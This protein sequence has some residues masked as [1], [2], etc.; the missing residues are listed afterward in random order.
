MEDNNITIGS[1]PEFVIM[2]GDSVANALE[3]FS[4][5]FIEDLSC[6]E[7]EEP[8]EEDYKNFY[9]GNPAHHLN[10]VLNDISIKVLTESYKKIAAQQFIDLFDYYGY[11]IKDIF[12]PDEI[13]EKSLKEA[14]KLI[15]KDI[16]KQYHKDIMEDKKLQKGIMLT[17]IEQL[18]MY[19]LYNKLVG[20]EKTTYI[21]FIINSVLEYENELND[22]DLLPNEIQEKIL[23]NIQENWEYDLTPDDDYEEYFCSAELGCDAHSVTGEM[24]PK[25]GNNPIEHFNEIL[26]LMKELEE[27]LKSD[28][29]CYGKELQ[30]KAGTMIDDEAEGE[31]IFLGGHIHLGFD[32]IGTETDAIILSTFVG[33]PLTLI[34]NFYE[35]DR[36]R[37]YGKFGEYN[38]KAIANEDTYNGLEF[39]MPSSWL[40]SPQ[41]TIG[42]L[43]LAYTTMHEI[44]LGGKGT[45]KHIDF[46]KF[47]WENEE[48]YEQEKWD[49]LKEK[50]PEI[51][52][53]VKKMR[54]YPEYK[55]YIDYIFDMIERG[56]S[57]DSNADIL[58]TWSELF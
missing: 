39:R 14:S 42:A 1:D 19:E 34:E 9:G 51:Y 28:I 18:D 16:L 45:L 4:K 25:Y 33:I 20:K 32:R 23:E 35:R 24:R 17:H 8:D 48:Q 21:D 38:V 41:I 10:E 40:V 36:H 50:I 27:R 5:V 12:N 13:V 7:P 3:I 56:E 31:F 15:I 58:V 44:L 57:W 55:E 46:M 37:V 53:E 6:I 52:S 29:I 47:F 54:L 49:V 2:C 30:I 26:K 22:F 43:A 11:E